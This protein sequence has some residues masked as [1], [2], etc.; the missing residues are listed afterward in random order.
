MKRKTNIS[1]GEWKLMRLLWENGESS[2]AQLVEA[3]ENDTAWNKNTVFTMLKRLQ[4]KGFVKLAEEKRPQKYA[5][6]ISREDASGYAA[7]SFFERVYNGSMAQFVSAIAGNG[8]LTKADIEDM[9]AALD[10]AE[11]AINEKED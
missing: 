9:R 3:L 4:E 10:E 11:K 1:N 8:K 7:N 6:A 2:V 5:A